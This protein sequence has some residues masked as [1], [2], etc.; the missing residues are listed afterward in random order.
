M[1]PRAAD[2]ERRRPAPPDRS[3]RLPWEPKP[4]GSFLAS[5]R[6]A[7]PP[8]VWEEVRARVVADA[9]RRCEA[10]HA[11]APLAPHAVWRYDDARAVQALDRLVALCPPCHRAAHLAEAVARGQGGDAVARLALVNGWSRAEAD[12]RVAEAFDRWR[13]RSRRQWRVD[14]SALRDYGAEPPRELTDAG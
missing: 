13:E 11:S 2:R 10:C 5:V 1:G 8:S 7:V 9:N 14:L 12:R 3:E 4:A 6:G